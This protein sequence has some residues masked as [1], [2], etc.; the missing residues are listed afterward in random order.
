MEQQLFILEQIKGL[1][2][3]YVNSSGREYASLKSSIKI[4]CNV[5]L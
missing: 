3:F 5:N 2:C 4:Q 1:K